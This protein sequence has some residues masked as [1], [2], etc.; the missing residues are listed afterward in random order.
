MRAFTKFC[1]GLKAFA[2]PLRSP[3]K[4]LQKPLGEGNKFRLAGEREGGPNLILWVLLQVSRSSI[5]A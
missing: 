4:E 3:C 1:R 2:A 5:H